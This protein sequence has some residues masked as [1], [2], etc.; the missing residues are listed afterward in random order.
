MSVCV[1]LGR[2]F[3][4]S[5]LFLI[6]FSGVNYEPK[7]GV[8]VCGNPEHHS[9]SG[10]SIGSSHSDEAAL[11]EDIQVSLCHHLRGLFQFQA[12]LTDNPLGVLQLRLELA[13]F[14]GDLLEQLQRHSDTF[15]WWPLNGSKCNT[16]TIPTGTESRRTSPHTRYLF[17]IFGVSPGGAVVTRAVPPECVDEQRSEITLPERLR[18]LID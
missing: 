11:W 7:L 2:F 16:E 18:R 4:A 17:E 8:R 14:S 3:A 6:T 12:G 1:L 15:V 13:V 5:T 9:L 10:D